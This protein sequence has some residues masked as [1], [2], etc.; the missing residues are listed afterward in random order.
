M[1]PELSAEDLVRGS[2]VVLNE[3][4]NVVLARSGEVTGEVVILKEVLDDGAGP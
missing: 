1:H 3:S 4:L 2:E